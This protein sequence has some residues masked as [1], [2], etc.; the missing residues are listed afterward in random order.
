MNKLCEGIIWNLHTA[1][2]II[3]IYFPV[4]ANA[5]LC[6]LSSYHFIIT[7]SIVSLLSTRKTFYVKTLASVHWILSDYY[8]ITKTGSTFDQCMNS[9]RNTNCLTCAFD[10][11]GA[12]HL[13]RMEE[14]AVERANREPYQLGR[15]AIIILP[16]I[17]VPRSTA[18]L[19]ST[20]SVESTGMDIGTTPAMNRLF[21]DWFLYLF[22]Q[23]LLILQVTKKRNSAF[24]HQFK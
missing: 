16:L 17:V 4:T 5:K 11:D 14:N 19:P 15:Q 21:A 10:V 8:V 3:F 22:S 23:Y 2:V 7:I 1:T 6:P 12:D 18:T 13:P 20:G 24:L 9:R